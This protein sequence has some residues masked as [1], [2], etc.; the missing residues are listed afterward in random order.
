MALLE[1]IGVIVFIALVHKSNPSFS[2][3]MLFSGAAYLLVY[4]VLAFCAIRYLPYI[5]GSVVICIGSVVYLSSDLVIGACLVVGDFPFS[6]LVIMVT[7]WGALTLFFAGVITT[8]E[9]CLVK[10]VDTM[11][12]PS[13]SMPLLNKA[14]V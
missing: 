4:P 8:L 6:G 9:K 12:V 1:V 11:P 5:P 14:S 10:N 2:L 13:S 3:V 7:Y